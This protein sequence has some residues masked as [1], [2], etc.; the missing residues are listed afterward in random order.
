MT[1]ASLLDAD[2]VLDAPA[3]RD[4][5]GRV[6]KLYLL[7]AKSAVIT[8]TRNV[9]KGL[10][11][12]TR[13]AVKGRLWRA[14]TSGYGP[15][16]VAL[17]YE[18]AG[19]IRLNSKREGENG[20]ISRT[21]GAMDF[22]SRS[23]RIT[24]HGEALAIPLPAAGARGRDRWLTPAAWEKR[25]GI[26]LR[27]VPR[28]NGPALLVADKAVLSGARQIARANTARRAAAG[29]GDTTVPIFVLLRQVDFYNSFS[30][31]PII[32]RAP[33]EL[34]DNFMSIVGRK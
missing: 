12:L 4:E 34:R 24:P 25:T 10:E 6:T 1:R 14:W 20:R 30:I 9:E 22:F 8:T 13:M 26:K 5:R 18:P 29:R 33:R 32:A 11:G 27:L 23:G 3:L 28:K 21:Y 17:A 15:K 31:E 16:G 7:A 19:W 2:L